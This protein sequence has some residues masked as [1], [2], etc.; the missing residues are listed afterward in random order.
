M[1]VHN[2]IE[3]GFD[4]V[5]DYLL[6]R[7]AENINDLTFTHFLISNISKDMLVTANDEEKR[8]SSIANNLSRIHMTCSYIY[9]YE[10]PIIC[11]VDTDWK[12][13]K[14]ILLKAYQENGVIKTLPAEKQKIKSEAC[15]SNKFMTK[16][17]RTLILLPL[18]IN[19]EN[20]GIIVT[21]T[22]FN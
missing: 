17:R 18:F 21:E 11:N 13:P 19:E 3:Y 6:F 2:I 20:Y 4:T 5:S 22:E 9:T 10:E 1:A 12:K 15:F 14:H 16:R 8:F 7:N